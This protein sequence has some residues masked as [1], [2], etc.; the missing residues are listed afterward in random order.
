[1]SK[2]LSV[3]YHTL[4]GTL[5]NRK[6]KLRP[7]G[8]ALGGYVHARKFA[9]YWETGYWSGRRVWEPTPGAGYYAGKYVTKPEAEWRWTPAH[10]YY[11]THVEVG[12]YRLKDLIYR[13][14]NSPKGRGT[15]V[16]IQYYDADEYVGN[17]K[18]RLEY[19]ANS[20]VTALEFERAVETKVWDKPKYLELRRK[21]V[22]AERL[23][24]MA[25]KLGALN[26]DGAADKSLG[27]EDYLQLIDS[28]VDS[29][30]DPP[31]AAIERLARTVANKS[32]WYRKDIKEQYALAQRHLREE[33][34]KLKKVY[35]WEE[36]PN[37]PK[38]W[39]FP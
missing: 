5:L 35:T 12:N 17:G 21:R 37:A 15:G 36:D 20:R 7:Q 27:A 1:M 25:M 6:T 29:D 23:L 10:R 16:R 2:I 38:R 22:K 28:M 4:E 32:G 14:R 33:A 3:T 19:D 8:L 9:G 11:P 18:L 30:V 31:P 26:A 39:E 34:Y 13:V 24:K